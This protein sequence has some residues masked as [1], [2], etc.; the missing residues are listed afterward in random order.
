MSELWLGCW[1]LQEEA[2]EVGQLIG[3]LGPFPVGDHPDKKGPIGPR[4]E[5]EIGDLYAALDYFVSENFPNAERIN[6]Q[7]VE[8][9]AKFKQWGLTGIFVQSIADDAPVQLPLDLIERIDRI[10]DYAGNVDPETPVVSVPTLRRMALDSVGSEGDRF[11]GKT[12]DEV[13][14]PA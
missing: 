6:E 11:I 12:V 1:K 3:K 5:L 14:D 8:K 4:L 2:G 10:A 7:R 9:F 13:V